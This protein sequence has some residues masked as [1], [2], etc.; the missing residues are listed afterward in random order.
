GVL[1]ECSFSHRPLWRRPRVHLEF[2]PA[3]RLACQVDLPSHWRP[4]AYFAAGLNIFY[5]G[6]FKRFDVWYHEP[7]P[8]LERFQLTR[9]ELFKKMN[10]AVKFL[11]DC[12]RSI[13]VRQKF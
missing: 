4:R 13:P 1:R 6:E 10:V 3:L 2:A 12:I 7:V 5:R 9:I 11:R 8:G